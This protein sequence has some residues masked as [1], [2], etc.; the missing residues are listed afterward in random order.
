MLKRCAAAKAYHNFAQIVIRSLA[1]LII[2]QRA[3][4]PPT[5]EYYA[6]RGS[7][8]PARLRTT[9]DFTLRSYVHT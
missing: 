8:N 2:V 9:L 1:R 7:N 5:D 6:V 3:R 4:P